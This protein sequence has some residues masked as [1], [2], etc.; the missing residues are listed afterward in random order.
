MWRF[1]SLMRFDFKTMLFALL[2]PRWC[3]LCQHSC[4]RSNNHIAFPPEISMYFT[5]S[6]VKN[7]VKYIFFFKIFVFDRTDNIRAH[8]H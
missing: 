8:T 6:V 4:A 5:R 2:G 3:L 7:A 1:G